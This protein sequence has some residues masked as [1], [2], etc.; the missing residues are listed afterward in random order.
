MEQELYDVQQEDIQDND[1]PQKKHALKTKPVL[2][3]ETW[4]NLDAKE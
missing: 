3:E 2:E 4:P 1:N